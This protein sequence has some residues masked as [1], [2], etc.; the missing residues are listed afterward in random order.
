MMVSI[1]QELTKRLNKSR[2]DIAIMITSAEKASPNFFINLRLVAVWG[3][4]QP[5]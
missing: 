1:S 4:L 5:L 2:R 3:K